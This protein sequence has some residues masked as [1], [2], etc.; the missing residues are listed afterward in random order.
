[1]AATGFEKEGSY[2]FGAG[3]IGVKVDIIYH[4]VAEARRK[5]ALK[6]GKKN[7]IFNIKIWEKAML[8]KAS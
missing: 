7:L 3:E 8:L 1:M 4:W 6:Q 2:L 5:Q